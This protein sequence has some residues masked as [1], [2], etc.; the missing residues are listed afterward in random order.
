MY[1]IVSKDKMS[2]RYTF[3]KAVMFVS[4]ILNF[5]EII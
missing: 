1:V 2:I 4:F 3:A 5:K